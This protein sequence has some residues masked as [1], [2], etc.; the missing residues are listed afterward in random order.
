MNNL[1]RNT[2]VTTILLLSTELRSTAQEQ[3][4]IW[5][6]DTLVRA[7]LQQWQ[8][9]KF[10]VIIHWGPYSQWGVVESWS[11]CPE[12]EP[13]CKRRGP[14]A[15]DYYQY[16]KAYENIRKEFNPQQFNPQKW[17][18]AAKGAGMKYLVFTTKHHDGF[19][20]FDSKY[21]N[22]K[23]TDTGSVFS[24]NPRSNVVKEVFTAFR[25]NGF[26][27]GAY[28][29]KPDWHSENYWW[30]YFPVYDRNVNYDPQKYPDRW[31]N[32]QQYT[33]NQIQE[34]MTGY[35]S[36][37]V[38]WLDGGWVRPA[39]SLDDETRSWLGKR[40]WI[41][42]ADIPRIAGMARKEQPGIL[43]V[44]R[45]IHGEYENYR[46]PEQQVPA[47]VLSYP[48]E[49]CITLGDGWYSYGPGGKY[50][51]L[52]E[53][54]HLLINIVSKGGNLLLGIGPDKSGDLV[55]EVYQR[56]KEIGDWMKINGEAIYATV[57][58]SPYQSGPWRFTSSR[59]GNIEYAF[60][61]ADNAQSSLPAEIILPHS[62]LQH[63][64]IILLGYSK[65]LKWK[66]ANDGI[67]IQIPANAVEQTKNQP[68]WTFKVSSE[69]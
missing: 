12:D 44:D 60:Y 7:K 32:F 64:K 42:D 16:K 8:D 56:L 62:S 30:P 4:Y 13:W 67:H 57:P 21:T 36:I 39:G 31:K 58:D 37:D 23:I 50:K 10:G 61:L 22:Y 55:P 5:P 43:V 9:W 2:I 19:C 68:A 54:I 41:Q 29:S 53:V 66:N 3:P 6:T 45:T 17:A 34:L 25:E 63:A 28:F 48:W 27:I 40:Q 18:A 26:H 20:M 15:N 49:S 1:L 69:L 59:T 35:G 11:L 51:S 38:L 14:Y 33:F 52:H 47:N 46:T 65:P 24:S